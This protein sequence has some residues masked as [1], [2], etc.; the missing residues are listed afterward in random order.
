MIRSLALAAIL[1][2]P[3]FAQEGPR[4]SVTLDPEGP[5]TVGTPLRVT[6][7]VLVPSYMPRP[8][9]W[10]D[11]QIADA[12]T[13]LPERATHPVTQGVGAESWSGVSRTWEIIPQRAA[14][15]DLGV[16]E[17][18]VTYAD[19]ETNAPVEA[20][21]RLPDIAF[22]ATVP[23]GAEGM[24]PFLAA[25]SLTLTATLDGLPEGPKPGDAF[26]LTLTTTAAGPP[27]MLLP[28]LADRLPTPEGLRAYPRQPT[29]VDGATATRTEAIAYVIERPGEF[30]LSAVSLGWWN[31]EAQAAETA[32]TETVIIH[33]EAPPGWRP[34]DEP[35]PVRNLVFIALMV[36]A[37][38]ATLVLL[39]RRRRRPPS[40]A[41]LRRALRAAAQSAPPAEIRARLAA[42]RDSLARPPDTAS[43]HAVER[44]LRAIERPVYGLSVGAE[45]EAAARRAFVI[46]LDA[47]H[48]RSEP[49]TTF[50]AALN[51]K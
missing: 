31:T 24:E 11:L 38:A 35:V 13:R 48:Y 3:A 15:Y 17:V 30:E 34:S 26:T 46:E 9:V 20:R 18:V 8:P 4:V 1:A 12:I 19:P 23:A 41:A 33:V 50:L 6:A 25:T 42:W 10:P 32:T 40:S 7:T 47:A 28:A 5:V 16:S 27:A 39:V 37:G 36:L 49:P 14:D 22:S 51:P 21:P 43:E 44:A 45:A 2:A 29:L